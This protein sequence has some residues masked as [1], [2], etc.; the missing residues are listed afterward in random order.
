M[1]LV[2]FLSQLLG[3][4]KN[5]LTIVQGLTSRKKLIAIDGLS[6]KY[7]IERLKPYASSSVNTRNTQ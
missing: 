7:I 6:Q 5:Q 2:T 1:E 3:V 4:S